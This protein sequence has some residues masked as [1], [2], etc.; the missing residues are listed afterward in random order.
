MK[1]IKLSQQVVEHINEHAKEAFPNECC[2]FL[3]GKDR[4]DLRLIQLARSVDNSKEGDQRRRFEISPLDYMRAERYALENGTQLLGV[5]HS[6]PNHPAIA[7][8]HDLK[9]AMPFFS[10][11]IV[12]VMDGEISNYKS[13][14]LKDG[15]H[16]FFEESIDIEQMD[17][18]PSFVKNL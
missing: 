4:S 18:T 13:W 8:E 17:V 14:K 9:Q 16:A 15:E 3:Y 2:G 10:Y 12:S 7:S 6:H 11:V 5:Y 1:S